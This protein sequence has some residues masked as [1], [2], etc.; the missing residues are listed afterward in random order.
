MVVAAGDWGRF[1]LMVCTAT[2][3]ASAVTLV[4]GHMYL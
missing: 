1:G 2:R 3:S 4:S